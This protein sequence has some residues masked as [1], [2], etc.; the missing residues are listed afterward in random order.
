V[1]Q[2]EHQGAKYG[3]E[4]SVLFIANPTNNAAKAMYRQEVF[5]PLK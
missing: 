1:L 4:K 5:S 3:M 2:R